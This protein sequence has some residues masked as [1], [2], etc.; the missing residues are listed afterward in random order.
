LHLSA[1]STHCLRL[2]LRLHLLQLP[3]LHLNTTRLRLL[4]AILCRFRR[5]I[6]SRARLLTLVLPHALD[7]SDSTHTLALP[8]TN[9]RGHGSSSRR[10]ILH[11]DTTRALHAAPSTLASR[12]TPLRTIEP[13]IDLAVCL[14]QRLYRPRV[15][16]LPCDRLA[17]RLLQLLF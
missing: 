7:S 16:T 10:C 15:A 4:H 13:R 9:V 12:S 6:R 11:L 2:R 1:V 14:R 8:H 17:R 5:S 3:A